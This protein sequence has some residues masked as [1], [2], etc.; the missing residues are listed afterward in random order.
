MKMD[1]ELV[2]FRVECR[3]KEEFIPVID[4]LYDF[5]GNWID[6]ARKYPEYKFISK[7]SEYDEM[8]CIPYSEENISTFWEDDGAYTKQFLQYS[9]KIWRFK[10]AVK[11]SQYKII[12]AFLTY[13]L[14]NIAETIECCEV[15]HE[16]KHG[17]KIQLVKNGD[18]Y[19]WRT[20]VRSFRI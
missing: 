10:I 9:T 16:D 5:R 20:K 12:V 19:T 17:I 8:R 2:G 7:Y 15:V 13:M 18:E 6:V 11:Y 14:G 1:E 4:S 3:L